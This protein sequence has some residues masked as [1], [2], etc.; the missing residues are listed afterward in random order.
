[1]ALELVVGVAVWGLV[2]CMGLAMAEEC[3]KDIHKNSDILPE[4]NR[5]LYTIHTVQL[6]HIPLLH[7]HL[8]CPMVP[9]RKHLKHSSLLEQV[10]DIHKLAHRVMLALHSH[11]PA[12][13]HMP[14]CLRFRQD[15]L[16]SKPSN[17][18]RFHK[19]CTLC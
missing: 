13:K 9:G 18:S 19:L 12:E 6:G 17:V 16:L 1:M 4:P 14:F 3:P 15:R 10:Q 5:S 8:R 2:E 11:S 7:C